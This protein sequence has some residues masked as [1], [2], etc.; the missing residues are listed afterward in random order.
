[1]G[2][3]IAQTIA[4]RHPSRVLSL[5]SIYSTTGNTDLPSADP[6]VM[7]LLLAPA[8][9]EREAHIEHMVSLFKA[10]SGPGFAFDETWTRTLVTKAFDRSFYPEGTARQVLAVISQPDR[11]KRSCVCNGTDS[12]HTRDGRPALAGRG[13]R[14]HRLGNTECGNSYS[15]KAWVMIFLT[16]EHGLR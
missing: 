1:M 11:R 15:S 8:P 4:I 10:F 5:V 14:G 12:C 16:E 6:Q 7:K 13:W 2:G 9:R 3:M